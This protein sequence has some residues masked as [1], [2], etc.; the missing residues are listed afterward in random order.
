MSKFHLDKLCSQ[1]FSREVCTKFEIWP[2][3]QPPQAVTFRPETPEEKYFYCY[4]SDSYLEFDLVCNGLRECPYGEDEAS[5]PE[6]LVKDMTEQEYLA[7]L[8]SPAQQT[9]WIARLK[10]AGFY[11]QPIP[12]WFPADDDQTSLFNEG[13]VESAQKGPFVGEG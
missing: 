11:C 8:G 2:Q 4:R 5:C 3:P 12:R 13:P 10:L 1:S 6:V 7:Y 9:R